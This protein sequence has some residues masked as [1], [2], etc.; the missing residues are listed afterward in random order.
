MLALFLGDARPLRHQKRRQQKTLVFGRG[1]DSTSLDPI[2]TT[3]GETFKVT[4][5]MFEKLLN[6][7]EKD[8]TIHPGLATDW[9][10]AKDGKSYTFY[11]REGVKF[12]DGTDFNAEAVK[13]NFDR[14]MNGDAEK[15]PYYGMFGGY[16]KIKD[17]SLKTS[18]S[19]VSMK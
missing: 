15:F 14:W 6:Y 18:S 5:N 11:L 10:V 9:D 17:M 13:F 12:H 4:E 7:G 16:K 19:K 8:T 2:T 3:E 1:G